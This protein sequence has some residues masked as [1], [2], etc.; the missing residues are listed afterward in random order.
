MLKSINETIN[1]VLFHWLLNGQ[2]LWKC[3]NEIKTYKI[4]SLRNENAAQ[5][6][7]PV[8]PCG[9]DL[10]PCPVLFHPQCCGFDHNPKEDPFYCWRFLLFR[11][12]I[13]TTFQGHKKKSEEDI[14]IEAWNWVASAF[15]AITVFH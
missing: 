6:H 9:T 11:L 7:Q 14:N 12:C 2:T 1:L 15:V 5:V 4:S 13:K 3:M 10:W 8:Q